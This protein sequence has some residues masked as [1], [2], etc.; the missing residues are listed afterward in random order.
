MALRIELPDGV[1][2]HADT[3]EDLRGV[4]TTIRSMNGTKIIT[5]PVTTPAAEAAQ[6]I[7]LDEGVIRNFVRRLQSDGQRSFLKSVLEAPNGISDTELRARLGLASNTALAGVICGLVRHSKAAG[8][9]FDL[10]VKKRMRK[11]NGER[12]YQYSVTP[13]ARPILERMAA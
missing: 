3:P 9:P 4:L 12:T 2:I 10:M 13:T 1:V 8:I 6:G 5:T 11:V 7:R